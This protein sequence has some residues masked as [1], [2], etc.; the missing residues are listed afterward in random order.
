PFP[1]L[2]SPRPSPIPPRPSL[3]SPFLLPPPSL[4]PPSLPFFPPVEMTRVVRDGACG[5]PH[6]SSQRGRKT[7]VGLWGG[8]G[9]GRRGGDGMGMGMDDGGARRRGRQARIEEW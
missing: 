4:L 6:A 7:G 3:V 8:D 9:G 5:R 1:T 2:P